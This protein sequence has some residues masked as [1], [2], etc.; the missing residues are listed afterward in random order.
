MSTGGF[1]IAQ[2]ALCVIK[3][4]AFLCQ[5]SFG[6]NIKIMKNI[7]PKKFNK[8]INTI[9]DFNSEN[10][11]GSFSD[12]NNPTET[13]PTT[14]TVTIVITTANAGIPAKH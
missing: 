5:N 12:I 10:L 6:Q 8:R 3:F 2:S 14:A 1:Y 9:C 4:C 7:R 13:D 11:R